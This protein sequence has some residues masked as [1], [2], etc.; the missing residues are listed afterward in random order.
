VHRVDGYRRLQRR[1]DGRLLTVLEHRLV[2]QRFLL[3]PRDLAELTLVVKQLAS[4]PDATT[5]GQRR[6]MASLFGLGR[7]EQRQTSSA[8]R[9]R[10]MVG[11]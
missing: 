10:S 5:R 3:L 6:S 8:I 9:A 1:R 2:E 4:P 7:G 11:H